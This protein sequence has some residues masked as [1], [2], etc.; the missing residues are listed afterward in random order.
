MSEANA[1]GSANPSASTKESINAQPIMRGL[2]QPSCAAL[3][4]NTVRFSEPQKL[5]DTALF[6]A[7]NVIARSQT[8]N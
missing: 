2:G 4:L 6:D 5:H 8:P 3:P 1:S 7:K